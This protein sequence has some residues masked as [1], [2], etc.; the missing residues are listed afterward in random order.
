[1]SNF[2]KDKQVTWNPLVLAYE[3]VEQGYME[4]KSEEELNIYK[5]QIKNREIV[6]LAT[7]EDDKDIKVEIQQTTLYVA[8]PRKDI[9]FNCDLPEDEYYPFDKT[10]VTSPEG[11]SFSSKTENE[12]FVGDVVTKWAGV[13]KDTPFSSDQENTFMKMI[14]NIFDTKEES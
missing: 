4:F 13:P 12:Q 2:T 10:E 14:N 11:D 9:T 5:K 7:V 3:N 6:D 8:Y 1:M